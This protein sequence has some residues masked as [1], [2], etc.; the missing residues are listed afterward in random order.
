MHGG[1]DETKVTIRVRKTKMRRKGR[2][3]K[4]RG[5][6]G[7]KIHTTKFGLSWK[8]GIEPEPTDASKTCQS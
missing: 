2:C 8:V 5:R 4:K 1:R 7:L 3:I 6:G